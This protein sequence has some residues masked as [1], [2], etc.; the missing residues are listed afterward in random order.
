MPF[1]L[2]PLP[3]AKSALEPTMSARTLEFHYEKHHR[4][5]VDKLNKLTADTPFARMPLEDVIMNAWGHPDHTTIFNNAAQVWN[6]AFFWRSMMPKGGEKTLARLRKSIESDFGSYD[7]FEKSFVEEAVDQFGTGYVWLVTET[8]RL[9]VVTTQDAVPPTVLGLH[10]LLC[11]DLW[12]HA[13]YLDYQNDREKFVRGFLAHLVNWDF[14][15]AQL[16]VSHPRPA[17]SAT[18]T[19]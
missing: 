19:A 6:H 12:E 8:D 11:C 16:G 5:Y 9:K 14:A 17:M 13:Y 18:A 15:Q 2:L 4:G 3:Y 1:S 10:P 7:K